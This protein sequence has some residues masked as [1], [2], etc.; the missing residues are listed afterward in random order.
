MIFFGD[1]KGTPIGSGYT[2]Y[3]LSQQ[4]ERSEVVQFWIGLLE[5]S[6]CH[7]FLIIVSNLCSMGLLFSP[8]LIHMLTEQIKVY[9]E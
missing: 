9:N 6:T 3:N 5:V 8:F 2:N 1:D 4:K 7:E